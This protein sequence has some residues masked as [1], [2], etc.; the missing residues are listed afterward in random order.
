MLRA[1]Q[2]LELLLVHLHRGCCSRWGQ[3][4]SLHPNSITRPACA[5]ADAVSLGSC[6]VC[7]S[8]HSHIGCRSLCH[9]ASHLQHP[10]NHP[11][12]ID[13]LQR[14][15]LLLQRLPAQDGNLVDQIASDRLVLVV[16][17]GERLFQSDVIDTKRTVMERNVFRVYDSWVLSMYWPI[18]LLDHTLCE[19]EN[20]LTAG[21]AHWASPQEVVSNCH[22]NSAVSSL[23]GRRDLR[24]WQA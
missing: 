14:A 9:D 10:V 22:L 2:L 6:T 23:I 3:F 21:Q 5:V 11:N 12:R 7:S 16:K 15:G 4:G 17:S 19:R 1:D 13:G 18:E 24:C 20:A 8:M